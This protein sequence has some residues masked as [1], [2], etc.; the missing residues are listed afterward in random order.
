MLLKPSAFLQVAQPRVQRTR[1]RRARP[2]AVFRRGRVANNASGR[3]RRAADALV[4]PVVAGAEIVVGESGPG[5]CGFR[6]QA[7]TRK[8][9]GA[10][11]P[12][13]SRMGRWAG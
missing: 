6:A 1:L 5:R 8:S 9:K 10:K 13:A 12:A 2:V 11:K 4:R 7:A 3:R